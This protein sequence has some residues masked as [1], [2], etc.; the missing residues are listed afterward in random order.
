MMATSPDF[1]TW[2]KSRTFLLRGSDYGYSRSDF[3]DPFVFKGDDGKWHMIV[4]TY[5]NSK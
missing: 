4:S 2:S 5:A 1:K 3:R